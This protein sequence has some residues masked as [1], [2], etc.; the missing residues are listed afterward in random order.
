MLGVLCYLN[1]FFKMSI[2]LL[3][4]ICAPLASY[5]EPSSTRLTKKLAQ[6]YYIS[7]RRI[8]MINPEFLFRI[9]YVCYQNALKHFRMN[10]MYIRNNIKEILNT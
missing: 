10:I 7:T 9:I 1:G 4:V 2:V 6:S 3:L 8:L 5:I